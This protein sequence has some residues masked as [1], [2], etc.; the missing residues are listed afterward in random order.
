M[1]V[2]F[3]Y[4]RHKAW[5]K[6]NPRW[7][8]LTLSPNGWEFFDP[9]LPLHVPIYAR[10]QICIQLSAILTKLCHITRDHVYTIMFRM[11]TIGRNACWHFL[12]F[13]P[14]QSGF[15]DAN[16]T[17]IYRF[18]STLDYRCLSKYLQLW[19][20]YTILSATTQRAFRPMVDILSIWWWLRLIWRNSVKVADNWIIHN[21][22][23]KFVLKRK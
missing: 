1:S 11:S 23:N 19:Q 8:F 17:H 6:K 21:L 13:S 15:F 20:S 9:T 4:F 16:F 12:T 7:Y 18:L 10:L 14:K 3:L 2:V 22:H 5:V